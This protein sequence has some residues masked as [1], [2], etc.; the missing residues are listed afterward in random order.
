[1]LPNGSNNEHDKIYTSANCI[2]K[3]KTQELFFEYDSDSFVLLR[4]VY[5]L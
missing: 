5:V 1:M 3:K 2:R 4:H